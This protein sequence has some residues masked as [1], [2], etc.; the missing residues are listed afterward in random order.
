MG[1]RD[2][3]RKIRSKSAY[4]RKEAE[5]LLDELDLMIEN[6]EG[7]KEQLKKFEK[8]HGKDISANKDYYSKVSELRENLGLPQEIGI[9]EWKD[10]PSLR[11]KISG[12]GYYDQLGNELL[13]LGK[14]AISETGGLISIAEIVLK[15][16]KTRP[17]KLVPPKDVVKALNNLVDVELISPLR[18]LS[19]GVLVAEFIA[20][21]MSEDQEEIF[22]LASRHGFLTQETL[23]IQLG[24]SAD[25][26]SRVLE[27]LV[28]QGI[29]IK[30][31]TYHEGIKYWF[32]SLGQ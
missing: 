28:K 7:L 13:E 4:Q 24:W 29:A 22:N 23:L 14:Y 2:I 25:R 17:G 32:P 5:L 15:I 26:S 10:S 16:N 12:K 30:D 11:D 19:S 3:E 31:E 21:E 9:Y 27:E 20:I 8:K 6:I 18:K 1:L